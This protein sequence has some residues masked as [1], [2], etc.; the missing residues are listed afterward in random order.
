M[1][2][3]ESFLSDLGSVVE[4]FQDAYE[5]AFVP[6]FCFCFPCF[7]VWRSRYLAKSKKDLLNGV[8]N[9]HKDKF[10]NLGL[11]LLVKDIQANLMMCGLNVN[12]LVTVVE[13]IWDPSLWTDR[14]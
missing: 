7:L 1:S 5:D 4:P 10:E 2:R 3:W 11:L 8:V 6:L 12:N 9:L 13:I 14:I